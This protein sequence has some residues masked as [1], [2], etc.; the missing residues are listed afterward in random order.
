MKFHLAYLSGD[1]YGTWTAGRL[2]GDRD[3]CAA[4]NGT[5][6]LGL[7]SW[8]GAGAVPDIWSRAGGLKERQ[9]D[10]LAERSVPPGKWASREGCLAVL[11]DW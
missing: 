10:N 4:A 1:I 3:A 6:Y 7:W 11:N 8:A 2:C 9:P 5:E